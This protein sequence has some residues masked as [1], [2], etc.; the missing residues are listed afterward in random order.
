MGGNDAEDGRD[1]G[2][3]MPEATGAIAQLRPIPARGQTGPL[4]RGPRESHIAHLLAWRSLGAGGPDHRSS[5]S[6]RL[7][8]RPGPI[9]RSAE[10]VLLVH[11]APHRLD[12]AGPLFR[13]GAFDRGG[14]SVMLTCASLKA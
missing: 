14:S 1:R 3:V 2:E 9:R 12:K 11:G 5:G 10:R 4:L 8:R 7:S 6:A 13:P